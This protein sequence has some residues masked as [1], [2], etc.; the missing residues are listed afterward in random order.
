[1][2]HGGVALLFSSRMETANSPTLP[3]FDESKK[4]AS[5][6]Y[7]DANILYGGKNLKYTLP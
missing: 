4:L 3:N 2:I 6:A 7:I 5:I 1:M